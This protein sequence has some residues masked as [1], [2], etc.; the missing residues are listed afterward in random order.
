MGGVLSMRG[1]LNNFPEMQTITITITITITVTV[2]VTITI[3]IT[4]TITFTTSYGKT[5]RKHISKKPSGNGTTPVRAQL[6]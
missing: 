3:T 5:T 2:T 1:I 4:I 6:E